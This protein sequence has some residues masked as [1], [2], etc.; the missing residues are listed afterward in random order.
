MKEKK[1]DMTVLLK[2]N[3]NDILDVSDMNFTNKEK[4]ILEKI[5]PDEKMITYNN[6]IL[7]KW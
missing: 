2:S 7:L 3:K 4:S 5:A 1:P 6:N